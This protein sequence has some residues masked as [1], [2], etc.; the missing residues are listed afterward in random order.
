MKILVT[1]GAG[2][3]G[4]NLVSGLLND[5]RVSFIRV[6]DNLSTGYLHN[7]NEFTNNKKFEFVQGD[8]RDFNTCL[9]GTKGI[10][11]IS[12]QAALGSVPLSIEDP[13]LSHSV[14]VTGAL[15]VSHAAVK[16][17]VKRFVFA[18]SSATY[19]DSTLKVQKES[20]IGKPLSPYALNKYINELYSDLFSSCYGLEYVG[21]RYF[22]VFG[23]KQDPRGAYAAVIPLFFKA[24]LENFSPTINGDGSF[25][26]DFVYVKN[27]VEANMKGLFTTDVEAINTVYNIACG[28]EISIKELWNQIKR[29]SQSTA[30]AIH[31]PAR[32]GDIPHSVA[33]IE[34]ATNQLKYT[35][36]IKIS[37]GLERTYKWYIKNM[38]KL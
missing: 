12:H 17:G 26:R 8:I 13:L 35:G 10:D 25:S 37:S 23:P 29:I 24:A 20:V 15:N 30:E 14:N 28:E 9:E 32:K 6:L 33:D 11:A 1:G 4:S 19:G 21:L 3:I 18:S 7:L 38:D 36:N 16:N 34:R 31:G 27:I 2:F 5:E 22:N